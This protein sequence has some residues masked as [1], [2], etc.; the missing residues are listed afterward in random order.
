M[1]WPIDQVRMLGLNEI[2][3]CYRR[4]RLSVAEAERAMVR[5]LRQYGQLSPIVVCLREER[6]ELIDGFAR[7][8]AATLLGREHLAA[9]RIDADDSGAKAA[10]YG[11]NQVGRHTQELE[12]AWIVH[13]LVREDG[14]SQLRVAEL[15]GRHKSWVCRRLA[16]IERLEEPIRDELRLG[17]LSPSAARELV[18]LPAGNQA[19]VVSA[20]HRE[21]LNS[22]EVRGVVG[23]V[24]SAGNR[25][26]IEHILS[27]PRQVLGQSRE[28]MPPMY[29]PRLSTAGN[30]MWRQS[31]MLLEQ[32]GRLETWLRSRGLSELSVLDRK[33]LSPQLIRLGR[34]CQIVGGLINEL[35][36]EV[37]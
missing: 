17:L 1:N 27:Q 34:E 29:D 14:L 30:R 33:L 22:D 18:R 24:L 23:L 2:G 25:G 15:L 9:R 37:I 16:L 5:S 8:A 4:Y 12:E 13:A 26:Q 21:S 7:H 3:L 20:V 10:I 31:A 35:G 32:L 6:I 19:E 11:L 28:A 36:L